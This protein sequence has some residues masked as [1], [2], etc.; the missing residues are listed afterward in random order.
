MSSTT[1]DLAAALCDRARLRLE[2]GTLYAEIDTVTLSD[3]AQ[4]LRELEAVR[5]AAGVVMDAQACNPNAASGDV[6]DAINALR[7]A[8]GRVGGGQ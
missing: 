5:V 8:L 1:P 4:R 6:W 3:A 2:D 7:T